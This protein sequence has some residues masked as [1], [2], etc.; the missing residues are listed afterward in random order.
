VGLRER[1]NAGVERLVGIDNGGLAGE[2]GG[3]G[4]GAAL[5][6]EMKA[7]GRCQLKRHPAEP[8]ALDWGKKDRERRVDARIRKS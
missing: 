1:E 7:T 5:H 4:G 6:G 2:K 8:E 3:G